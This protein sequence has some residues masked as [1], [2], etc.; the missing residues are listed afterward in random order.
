M[1]RDKNY[2][3]YL[4]GNTEIEIGKS[5][6]LKLTN[7][8]FTVEVEIKVDRYNPKRTHLDSTILG[9]ISGSVV[10]SL[11]HLT[12]RNK[13]PYMGFLFNDTRA[14]QVIDEGIWYHLAFVYNKDAKTQTIYVNGKKNVSAVNK[15]PYIGKGA[16]T[17]GN[18]GRQN[19][20]FQGQIRGLK[21]WD[22]ALPQTKIAT[23]I[24]NGLDK[25]A[26]G[27]T[28][29]WTFKDG[30]VKTS[31]RNAKQKKINSLQTD[32]DNLILKYKNLKIEFDKVIIERRGL[33]KEIQKYK[34]ENQDFLALRSQLEDVKKKYVNLGQEYNKVKK[35][36]NTFKD[37]KSAVVP[38]A[39][40]IEDANIQI[41]KARTQLK[42]SDYHL[43]H[44]NMQ[45]KMIPSRTG[46][47]LIFPSTEDVVSSSDSLSTIDLEFAPKESSKV[48]EKTT[49]EIPDVKGLT[50]IMARRK[51]SQAG[52]L[53]EIKYQAVENT[54]KH[55]VDRVTKQIPD[56]SKD[57]EVIA[58]AEV[59]SVIII[60][61][62]KQIL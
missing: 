7:A 11:L 51:I 39:K 10:S 42:D 30:F 21:F 4:D 2:G 16:L 13:N 62:G 56:I 17:L 19:T 60:F 53:T 23:N 54:D 28:A 27:L 52:F 22:S 1:E 55:N 12:I 58:E 33:E 48:A 37:N 40:L 45:F 8:S 15:K 14:S 25:D 9:N 5:V 6:D 3:L 61:I 49:K 50:E 20:Y 46:D 32:V 31:D 24:T 47:S 57:P 41:T 44:V 34:A 18:W 35:E 43:G 26:N 29:Y 36:L 59:N 38:I